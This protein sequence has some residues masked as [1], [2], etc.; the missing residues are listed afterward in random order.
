M[1]PP[2]AAAPI[3]K[4]H[5]RNSLFEFINLNFPTFPLYIDF[6]LCDVFVVCRNTSGRPRAQAAFRPRGP[7]GP[8]SCK[9]HVCSSVSLASVICFYYHYQ[10]GHSHIMI[11]RTVML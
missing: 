2:T 8:L 10:I 6:P 5:L 4:P 9:H 1:M 3:S 11:L 7:Y